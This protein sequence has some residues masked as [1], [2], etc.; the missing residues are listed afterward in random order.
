MET[1]LRIPAENVI[2]RERV[3]AALPVSPGVAIGRALRYGTSSAEPE[4]RLID[5]DDTENE[6]AALDLAIRNTRQDIARLHADLKQKLDSESAEIFN[7]HLMI[8]SDPGLLKDAKK[9]IREELFCAEYAFFTAAARYARV[10][11]EMPDEYFRE[12]ADDVRDVALRVVGQLQKEKDSSGGA[13][14]GKRIIFARDL[15]PSETAS[16]DRNLV[17]GF[18]LENGSMTSHTSILARSLHL[19]AVVGLPPEAMSELSAADR[20]IIDGYSGK[21]ILNPEKRTEETYVLKAEAAGKFY[22]GLQRDHALQ[23]ETRDGFTVQLAANL[24]SLDNLDEV[25]SSGAQGVGLFRTEFL[26]FRSSALPGEE[27]QFEIYRDLMLANEHKPVIIR[28]FDVGGDKFAPAFGKPQEANP[29]LGLR[30]IRLC[31][32]EQRELFRAQLKALL[33]AGEFGDLRIMLPMVSVTEEIFETRNLILELHKELAAEKKS[34]SKQC[35]LGVMIETPAAALLVD[36]I[37]AVAD[38]LSIG[39]NDLV[40]YTLAIDRS[41]ESV[42]YLYQPSH[43]VILGLI[44]RCVAAARRHNIWVGICGQMAGEVELVPILLG[45]GVNEL[46]MECSSIGAVR[47]LIRALYLHQAEDLAAQV[48]ECSTAAEALELSR[49]LIRS[50]DPELADNLISEI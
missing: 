49:R 44:A 20:V 19:P 24:S 46:S 36:R 35:K 42:S 29:F 45:L 32:R 23:A 6:L 39:S 5:A 47:R 2:G 26:L 1:D 8:V 28:T 41:N 27:E 11:R 12:R 43:P 37:S 38:F 10:L 34:F 30:G 31:L 4:K 50:A 15:A 9:L 3:F 40:Q 13:S 7:A 14:E 48:L 33:R 18:A 16:L 17:L 22:S 25:K 21:V